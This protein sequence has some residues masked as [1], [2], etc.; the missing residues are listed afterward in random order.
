MKTLLGTAVLLLGLTACGAAI[1]PIQYAPKPQRV[2]QPAQQIASIIL[3]NTVQGCVS[4]PEVSPTMLVVKYVC[5]R[6]V[7]NSVIR[8]AQIRS[9]EL[10]QS[11]EWYRVLVKHEGGADDFS[12]TS[13]SLDDMKHLADAISAQAGGGDTATQPADNKT[14]I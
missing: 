10:S 11:G 6:G 14:Q 7:G 9:I 3:A 1:R 8:F 13:K 4:E 12:W 2:A 5:S